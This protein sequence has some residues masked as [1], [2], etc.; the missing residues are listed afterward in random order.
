MLRR[1]GWLLAALALIAACSDDD[2]ATDDDGG[3]GGSGAAG[4][5]TPGGGPAGVCARWNADRDDMSEGSWSGSVNS[6]DPGDIGAAARDNALRMVNLYRFLAGLPE[7]GT[8]ATLDQKA[9][10]CALMMHANDALSHTP[11]TSWNCYSAD[12]AEAAGKSNLATTPGVM[13]VDL[14]MADPGNETTIGHRRWILSN[15]LGPIGLGSTSEYS[16]MWVLGQFGSGS[17]FT[18]FPSPGPFPIEAMTASFAPVDQTGWTI[19]SNSIELSSAEVTV[20][21]AGAPL[22]VAVT[23]LLPNYGSASALR[24]NPQGWSA[25]AGRTYHVEVSGIANPFGYDVE[26]VDCE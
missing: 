3:A 21:D 22:P 1:A 4:G 8:D 24:F 16:C 25:E 2:G 19:Q 10:A 18:A 7:V 11:P 5:D 20:S 26:M 13:A 15:G 14:Y 17:S 6:C 12:G 9:Q 23:P